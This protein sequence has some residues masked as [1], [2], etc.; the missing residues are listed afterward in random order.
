MKNPCSS[1]CENSWLLASGAQ[2]EWICMQEHAS[3]CTFIW[4]IQVLIS[5][6]K[7]KSCQ[8]PWPLGYVCLVCELESSIQCIYVVH[9]II[10]AILKQFWFE[11]QLWFKTILPGFLQVVVR[12]A[13][14]FHAAFI[15]LHFVF[16][17]VRCI[18][19]FFFLKGSKNS[20]FLWLC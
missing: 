18:F 11:K 4:S 10:W 14:R 13:A 2:L 19:F 7:E 6:E 20:G 1:N 15:V 5:S 8:I 16:D 12:F 9:A 17:S 3:L